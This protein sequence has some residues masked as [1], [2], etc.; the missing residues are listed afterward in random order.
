[1]KNN[2]CARKPLIY[3]AEEPLALYRYDSPPA[4]GQK[5]NLDREDK[6][7]EDSRGNKKN[8]PKVEIHDLLKKHFTNVI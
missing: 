8:K 6:P 4:A 1:M 5:R 7:M 2:L 3:H